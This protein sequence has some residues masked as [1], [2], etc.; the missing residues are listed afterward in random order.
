M[1]TLLTGI[2]PTG[3]GV[4]HLGNY[5][6]SIKNFTRNNT[7]VDKSIFMIADVHAT[8]LSYDRTTLTEQC[9]RNHAML[10]ACGVN[11]II[12]RQSSLGEHM[13]LSSVLSH[14]MSVGP[15]ERMTQ[16]TEKS[17]VMESVPLGLLTYP[18]L[19]AADILLH[20]ADIVPVGDDQTQ[21]MQLTSEIVKRFNNFAGHYYFH[22]P[23]YVVMND[24]CKRIMALDNPMKKMSKSGNHK[25][26]IF[27]DDDM[28]TVNRKYKRAVTDTD[29][30]DYDFENR[31]GLKNLLTILS[32]ITNINIDDLIPDYCGKGFGVLKKDIVEAHEK[33]IYPI[34]LKYKQIMSSGIEN[35]DIEKLRLDV[36]KVIRDVYEISGL[37]CPI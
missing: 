22:S 29:V 24:A 20:K 34:T 10:L 15:L 16:F 9:N 18:V 19:M 36:R 1:T 28:D 32:G 31:P 25:G 35:N 13:L 23:R 30:I 4:P 3:T 26:V 14:L 21:H 6:G 7:N 12:Y 2:Q 37:A 11:G 8:T 27:L 17:K 33:Y 5:I